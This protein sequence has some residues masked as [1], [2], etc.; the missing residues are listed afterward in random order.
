MSSVSIVRAAC[1]H[2][3]P[4][5]CALHV[6]VQDGRAIR[7]QGDPDHPPTRGVLCTKVARYTERTYHPQRLLHPLRRIGRKGEGRFERISWDAALDIVAERLT[8]IARRDPQ[9]IVP[10]SFAGT[11]GL[12]QSEGMAAR[13]FH[14]LG[15]SLLD[16]TICSSAGTTALR[17][18]YGTSQGMHLEHFADSKLILI[19]GSNPIT[20]SVHF[21]AVAQEAKRRGAR[22]VA[23]DPYRSLTAEKCHQHIALLPGTDA[24][25]A[26]GMMHVL[27]RDNLLDHEYIA[28]HTLGF[29]ELKTRARGYDPQRVAGIC[30]IPAEPSSNWHTPTAPP[31]LRR[32]ASTMDCSVPMA[33]ATRCARWLACLHWWVPG[34]IL[35][36]VCCFRHPALRRSTT[37]G[38]NVPT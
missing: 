26:L 31:G 36:A 34:A 5:T 13:F 38:C 21:W 18:T 1:P 20:S 16:R 14:K 3:C 12:V 4:D 24:A 11:M 9:A 33:V 10:Y 15:A 2:D 22:L 19:W 32:F 30:G 6:S 37:I 7:V 23:I 29:A 35:P 8:E 25:L 17:Y 27:I 28:R